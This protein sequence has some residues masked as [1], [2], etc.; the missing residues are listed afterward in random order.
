MSLEGKVALITGG[1]KNL[2]A[3]VARELAKDGANLAVHYKNPSSKDEAVRL[4]FEL[5]HRYPSIKVVFYQGDLTSAAVVTRLFEDTVR[6][7]GQV[8]IV[9]NTVG[10]VIKKP[11]AEIT[12][13]EFDSMFAINSKA[14]FFILKEAATHVTD[15]GTIITIATALQ[16]A[17]NGSYTSC[18]GSMAPVEHFI[19]NLCKELQPRHISV[20]AVAFDPID[21]RESVESDRADGMDNRLT[22][23]KDIA[24]IVRLLCTDGGWITGQTLFANSGYTNR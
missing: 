23:L 4:V 22:M 10:K 24:P 16:G 8:D 5:K 1:A 6:D 20:N 15:G 3:E 11:I 14:A 2:G 18:T 13:E 17:F 12:E 7:F 21:S 9:V 19:K